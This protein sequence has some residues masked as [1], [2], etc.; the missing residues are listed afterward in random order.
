MPLNIKLRTTH[1]WSEF[2]ILT[3]ENICIY[4]LGKYIHIYI[5]SFYIRY[6]QEAAWLLMKV[7]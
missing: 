6:I 2:Q 1:T 3:K 4:I 7:L 5:F